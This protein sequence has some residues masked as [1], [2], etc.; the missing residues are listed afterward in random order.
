MCPTC[1]ESTGP[2]AA[3]LSHHPSG[4]VNGPGP[5]PESGAVPRKG[6]NGY[7]WGKLAADEQARAEERRAV[8]VKARQAAT[9]TVERD[10]QMFTLVKLPASL[11]RAAPVPARRVA[12]LRRLG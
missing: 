6:L 9:K 3:R 10:G 11:K 2:A 12:R 4:L 5:L 1:R 8:V 7:G